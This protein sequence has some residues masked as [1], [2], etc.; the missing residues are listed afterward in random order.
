MA[1]GGGPMTEKTWH[2]HMLQQQNVAAHSSPFAAPGH[3]SAAGHYGY[4]PPA[5]M[6]RHPADKENA[7]MDFEHGMWPS[8]AGGHGP[9]IT[10]AAGYLGVRKRGRD[11]VLFQ[12]FKRRRL[13]E[14]LSAAGV[15]EQPAPPAPV[16]PDP[17][18]I[19]HGGWRAAGSA[20]RCLMR[21]MI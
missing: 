16:N 2:E 4:Q 18:P 11:E 10:P 15:S 19:G 7:A 6:D 21:H 14:P 8:A 9:H 12:D 1:C 17:A 20:T 3:V 5:Q 13:T